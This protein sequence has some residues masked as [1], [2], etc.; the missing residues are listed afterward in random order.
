[1]CLRDVSL[2]WLLVSE[3]H[4]GFHLLDF[5]SVFE[6]EALAS[7]QFDSVTVNCSGVLKCRPQ[8]QNIIYPKTGDFPGPGTCSEIYLSNPRTAVNSMLQTVVFKVC[9]LHTHL[10][11]S[12]I[13]PFP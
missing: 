8:I 12:D 5:P 4:N 2:T 11:V 9:Y 6:H 13:L 3:N 1:M 7:V 10:L